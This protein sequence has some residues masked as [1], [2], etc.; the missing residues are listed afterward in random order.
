M[1][2][3]DRLGQ[4]DRGPAGYERQGRATPQVVLLI[5]STPSR[6]VGVPCGLNDAQAAPCAAGGSRAWV[7]KAFDS[8]VCLAGCCRQ[9][10]PTDLHTISHNLAQS[11][12]AAPRELAQTCKLTRANIPACVD[13]LLA[14][15]WPSATGAW[16]LLRGTK[17]TFRN[18]NAK[19]ADLKQVRTH[20][21]CACCI[22]GGAGGIM[23]PACPL[24]FVLVARL[25]VNLWVH[26]QSRGGLLK[27]I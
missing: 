6:C 11:P 18:T 26:E 22:C 20:A 10:V 15:L 5:R 12:H 23:R 17:A 27:G 8:T 19:E 16:D 14:S 24:K 7:S 25:N 1:P 21:A 9:A 3:I 13:V 2:G 4:G